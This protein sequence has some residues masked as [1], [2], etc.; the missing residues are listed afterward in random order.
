[1]WVSFIA[2]I[3]SRDPVVDVEG[4]VDIVAVVEDCWLEFNLSFLKLAISLA[5]SIDTPFPRYFSISLLFSLLWAIACLNS[6]GVI[7]YYVNTDIPSGQGPISLF[8]D[9]KPIK[10]GEVNFSGI[11]I[12]INN[13][14]VSISR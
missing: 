7:V 2:A 14:K 13:S 6:S 8:N 5:V 9:V 10:S 11:N 3:G 4:V 1:M 12:K